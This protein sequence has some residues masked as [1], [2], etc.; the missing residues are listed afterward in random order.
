MSDPLSSPASD[1]P[2]APA[3]TAALRIHALTLLAL[4]HA[5]MTP[6]NFTTAE[7]DAITGELTREM[8]AVIEDESAPEWTEHY[9]A[10]EQVRANTPDK[11]GKARP[12]V[13]IEFERH[14][15]GRRPRLRFEA[16]RLGPA[17]PA[18]G[19][20]GDGGLEAFTSGYY[21]RTHQD[22]G[23]LG[24]V[25]SDDE[26]TWADKLAK[27]SIKRSQPLAITEPWLAFP[28]EGFPQFTYRTGHHDELKRTLNVFHVLLGFLTV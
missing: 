19:Y 20:F 18:S 5:R 6:V 17:H 14:Q 11:L 15:R 4:G 3:Y 24:Y 12:I 16:K 22:V 1:A 28:G 13:D 7:E 10:R 26:P 27:E 9:S 2:L 23:M 25:Q 21:D 8:N